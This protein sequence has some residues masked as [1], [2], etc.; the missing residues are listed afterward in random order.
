M[1]VTELCMQATT[2]GVVLRSPGCQAFSEDVSAGLSTPAL[3]SDVE[4]EEDKGGAAA[5]AAREFLVPRS[6]T[7]ANIELIHALNGPGGKTRVEDLGISPFSA[8]QM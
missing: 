4:G 5:Q 2:A 8:P 1:S 3:Y 6:G 7:D